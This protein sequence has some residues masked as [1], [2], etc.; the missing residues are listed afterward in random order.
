MWFPKLLD[1]PGKNIAEKSVVRDVGAPYSEAWTDDRWTAR[2][3][4]R[5]NVT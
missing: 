5:R 3:G 4:E 1:G 2:A